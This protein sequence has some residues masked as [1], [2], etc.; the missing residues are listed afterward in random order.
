MPEPAGEWRPAFPGQRPPFRPGHEVNL[1]H[2]AFTPRIVEPRAAEL[3]EAVLAE[4]DVAY[5]ATPSYRPSL[6]AWARAEAQVELL[7]AHLAGRDFDDLDA[8]SA[9]AQLE[10]AEGRAAAARTR[11]GLDPLS[12]ARL[13]R[14]VTS[15]QL[16]GARWLTELREERERAAAQAESGD[17]GP[18]DDGQDDGPGE[19]R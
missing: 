17:A 6:H 4:P 14:D 16:D 2:G 19:D 9:R 7:A 5:L 10:R 12:R 13:G 18:A 3:V 8:L 15:M 1:R 11:L